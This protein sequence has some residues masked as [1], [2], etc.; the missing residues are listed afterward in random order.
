MKRSEF[1]ERV[2]EHGRAM[3]RHAE[4]SAD[5]TQAHHERLE[6]A[7]REHEASAATAREAY[8]SACRKAEADRKLGIDAPDP[9]PPSVGTPPHI[10]VE[11]PL[12]PPAPPVAPSSFDREDDR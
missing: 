12:P 1:D 6:R 8:A 10:A 11:A 4:R 9:A 5:L 3:G 2:R 7:A